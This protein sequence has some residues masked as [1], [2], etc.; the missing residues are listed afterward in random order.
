MS[1]SHSLQNAQCFL[2]FLFIFYIP[3]QKIGQDSILNGMV[4]LLLPAFIDIF[5]M[6]HYVLQ[7]L[8][9]GFI[10]SS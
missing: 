1:T 7:V 4:V 5:Y 6:I 9:K 3:H 2:P 10:Q 8:D